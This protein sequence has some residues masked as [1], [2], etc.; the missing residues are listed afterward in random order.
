MSPLFSVMKAL[1]TPHQETLIGQKVK[2]SGCPSQD[3]VV[4]EASLGWISDSMPPISAQRTILARACAGRAP[5]SG[6]SSGPLS[7]RFRAG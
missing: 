6:E 3:K 1:L 2:G 7:E 5:Q 4:C